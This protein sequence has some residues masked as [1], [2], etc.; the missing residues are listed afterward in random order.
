V[1]DVPVFNLQVDGGVYYA[2]GV[3]VHNCDAFTQGLNYLMFGAYGSREA[4]QRAA[5]QAKPPA[6]IHEIYARQFSSFYHAKIDLDG[7]ARN[8][9]LTDTS[10]HN[11]PQDRVVM[12]GG[13]VV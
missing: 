2:N 11:Y 13:G 12:P 3:L 5:T 7:Q 8:M 9:G 10:H 4:A 1:P 6:T